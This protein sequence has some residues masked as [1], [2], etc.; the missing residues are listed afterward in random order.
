MAGT[1]KFGDL[2]ECLKLFE[3]EENSPT[4]GGD[5]PSRGL[6]GMAVEVK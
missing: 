5:G 1:R 6:I 2:F 3:V 4:A